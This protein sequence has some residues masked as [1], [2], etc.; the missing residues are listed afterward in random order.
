M[1]TR[2]IFID[3]SVL[4]SA[5]QSKTGSKDAPIVAAAIKSRVDFLITLD[6]ADF[7]KQSVREAVKP[8]QILTPREFVTTYL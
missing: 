7:K 8:L 2:S 6:I 4:L 3:T 5:V 1:N